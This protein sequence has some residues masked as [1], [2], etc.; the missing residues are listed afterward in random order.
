[1][2]R[3]ILAALSLCVF[4]F[5]AN[6]APAQQPAFIPDCHGCAD[7]LT[8]TPKSGDALSVYINPKKVYQFYVLLVRSYSATA[9]VSISVHEIMADLPESAVAKR[10]GIRDFDRI[11]LYARTVYIS[12]ILTI[13]GKASWVEV[14]EGSGQRWLV[15]IY[16]I[17]P[18]PHELQ[19]KE[20]KTK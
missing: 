10:A 16:R 7:A 5:C 17:E 13:D 4:S 12:G 20:A 2:N 18:L 1:M 9:N 19:L 11:G 8:I 6:P 3:P 15:M 14:R